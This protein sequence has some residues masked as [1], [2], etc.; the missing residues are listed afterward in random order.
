M[1]SRSDLGANS[2]VG[3]GADA[4]LVGGGVGVSI[5]SEGDEGIGDTAG[6]QP[7]KIVM[8][9]QM[10]KRTLFIRAS[11]LQVKDSCSHRHLVTYYALRKHNPQDDL[12]QPCSQGDKSIQ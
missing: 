5:V 2:G 1:E 10:N 3:E 7:G 12:G 9:I 4:V 6:L 11:R 8:I